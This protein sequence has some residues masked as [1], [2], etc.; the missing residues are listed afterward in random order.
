MIVFRK[1]HDYKVGYQVTPLFV[2]TQSVTEMDIIMALQEYLGVGSLKVDSKSV[3]LEVSSIQDIVSIIIPHFDKYAE[4][5][6]FL[7]RFFEKS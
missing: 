3:I 2:L 5:N 7:I 4:V 6:L 1:R